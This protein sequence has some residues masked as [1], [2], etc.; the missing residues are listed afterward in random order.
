M[1]EIPEIAFLPLSGPRYPLSFRLSPITVLI[2]THQ[3]VPVESC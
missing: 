1:N 3:F 2:Y